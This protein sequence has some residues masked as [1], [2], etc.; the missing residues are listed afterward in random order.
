MLK[1]RHHPAEL[2][3]IHGKS[4]QERVEIVRHYFVDGRVLVKENEPWS[5]DLVNEW[6]RFPVG[7][8]DDQ[9]DAM[10]QYLAWRLENSP[11][12]FYLA[13]GEI[14]GSRGRQDIR[15]ER[16]QKE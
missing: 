8:H 1:E 16:R 9:V 5:V 14:R 11:R 4:K 2:R 3:P 10:S 12:Q 13:R 15:D 7:R 6:M